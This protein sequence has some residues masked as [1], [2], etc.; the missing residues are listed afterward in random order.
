MAAKHSE[1]SQ[2]STVH[3]LSNAFLLLLTSPILYDLDGFLQLLESFRFKHQQLSKGGKGFSPPTSH[4]VV[5]FDQKYAQAVSG[6]RDF[7]TCI[8]VRHPHKW[9][10]RGRRVWVDLSLACSSSGVD[11]LQVRL[12]CDLHH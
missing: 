9:D 7:T 6:R 1:R 5:C 4:R 3:S 8:R 12:T 2:P 11:G 10:D